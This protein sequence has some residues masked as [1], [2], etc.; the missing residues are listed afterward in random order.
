[1][2]TTTTYKKANSSAPTSANNHGMYHLTRHFLL[3]V[4]ICSPQYQWIIFPE[5]TFTSSFPIAPVPDHPKATNSLLQTA[6]VEITQRL[7]SSEPDSIT[8]LWSVAAKSSLVEKHFL[9]TF[10]EN[11]FLFYQTVFW[12]IWR[13]NLEWEEST[14]PCKL[15]VT[16]VQRPRTPSL[17][18]QPI[19]SGVS[20]V[21]LGGTV[22]MFSISCMRCYQ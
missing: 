2:N 14:I 4:L 15:L 7:E 13:I 9:A 1:M 6:A 11:C 3:L 20:L 10:A 19:R 22:L 18:R 12:F 8:S 21:I 5:M 17:S 16:S